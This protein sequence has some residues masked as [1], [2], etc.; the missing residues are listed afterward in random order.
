MTQSIAIAGVAWPASS[1]RR[2]F[3]P[4][5]KV[6]RSSMPEGCASNRQISNKCRQCLASR[7]PSE[8][9]FNTKLACP[10]MPE[11]SASHDPI[12]S[13]CRHDLVI[14][15]FP[16]QVL[17]SA[18]VMCSNMPEWC[19]SNHQISNNCSRGMVNQTPNETCFSNA[20]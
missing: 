10:N 1:F 11:L 8:A 9:F 16:Q 6:V 15:L 2:K 12:N 18:Q 3:F 17:S 4:L 5:A 7:A 20:K 14:H 13:N 19:T